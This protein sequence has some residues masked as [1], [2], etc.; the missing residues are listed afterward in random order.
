MQETLL[1]DDYASYINV[2]QNKQ[3]AMMAGSNQTIEEMEEKLPDGEYGLFP[4]PMFDGES[5]YITVGQLELPG[6]AGAVR[7][8][9]GDG[10]VLSQ[11]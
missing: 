9:P 5:E 2:F 8:S 6:P 1:S 3:C 11:H 4:F 10:C 7:Q